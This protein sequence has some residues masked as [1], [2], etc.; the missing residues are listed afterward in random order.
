MLKKHDVIY[1]YTGINV[2][3]IYNFIKTNLD[4]LL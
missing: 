4:K 1:K 3:N 2:L